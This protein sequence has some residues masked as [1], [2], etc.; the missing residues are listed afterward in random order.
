MRLAACSRA[1]LC[2][3]VETCVSETG[4]VQP[5][6]NGG[7]EQRRVRFSSIDGIERDDLPLACEIWREDIFKSPWA[8]RE[9]MKLATLFVRYIA[10]PDPSLVV[11]REIESQC[12]LT[13]EEVMRSF[14]IMRSYGA[15][16][17]FTFQR[18]D[19]R[20]YLH[21]SLLQ[22]LRVLETRSRFRQLRGVSS[23]KRPTPS[24]RLA[25]GQ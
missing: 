5:R 13:R 21:L 17:S 20:V 2:G 14:T 23:M 9:A 24:A 12:Q 15:I 10:N 3:A 18:D 25:A 4:S 8:D 1:V 16:D 6:L 19:V 11:L 22:R 7:I